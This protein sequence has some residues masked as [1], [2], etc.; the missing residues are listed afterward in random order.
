MSERLPVVI[1]WSELSPY[2]EVHA[3][4]VRVI[5]LLGQHPPA[6][7]QLPGESIERRLWLTAN[8]AAR[9]VSEAMRAPA[10][11]DQVAHL[12]D[13]DFALSVLRGLAFDAFEL[14]GW[15]AAVFDEVAVGVGVALREVL[16]CEV[17]VRRHAR[18]LVEAA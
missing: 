5:E 15:P 16:K 1:G 10:L 2:R 18:L 12:R 11:R 13:A 6:D 17:S 3:L 8:A 9:S 4:R 14:A 7:L